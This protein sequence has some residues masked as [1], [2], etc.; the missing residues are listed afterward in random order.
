MPHGLSSRPTCRIGPFAGPAGEGSVRKRESS[1]APLS[2]C[3]ALKTLHQVW[4]CIQLQAGLQIGVKPLQVQPTYTCTHLLHGERDEEHGGSLGFPDLRRA[5]R[6]LAHAARQDAGRSQALRAGAEGG[7]QGL[8]PKQGA[9][10]G[11]RS[12]EG[13]LSCSLVPSCMHT[14]ASPRWLAGLRGPTPS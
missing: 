9:G 3:C 13:T 7:R 8:R 11:L 10:T 14:C 1:G 12:V 5:G 4:R 2:L 6:L